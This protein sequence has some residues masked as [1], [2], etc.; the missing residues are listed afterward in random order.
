MEILWFGGSVPQLY[1]Y[2]V[3]IDI[4]QVW[5]PYFSDLLELCLGRL[6]K[7]CPYK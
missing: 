5:F 3:Y 7:S 4:L 6:F 2:T 1:K